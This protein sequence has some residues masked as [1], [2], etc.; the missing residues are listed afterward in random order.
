VIDS[1]PEAQRRDLVLVAGNYG[2]AGALEFYG[3]RVGLPPVVS[4]AGSFWFFGPGNLPGTIS[5]S[6]GIPVTR[7]QRY[8]RRVTPLGT[9]THD[10]TRWVVDE[11]RA[12]ALALCEE[13]YQTLQD[14]WPSLRPR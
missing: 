7:L 14:L 5:L 13:P 6:V 1:L 11:E 8:C 10:D 3:A 9:I 12:V 4:P 2:E